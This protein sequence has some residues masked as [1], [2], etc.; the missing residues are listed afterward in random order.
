MHKTEDVAAHPIECN[1][2]I[3]AKML[4]YSICTA[5]AAAW[6]QK[7]PSIQTPH[8]IDSYHPMSKLTAV[9]HFLRVLQ[10]HVVT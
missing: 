3:L 10:G 5:A 7:Q 8:L 2:C 1:M 4:Q 9:G 6:M